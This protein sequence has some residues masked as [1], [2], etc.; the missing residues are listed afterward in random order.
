M[1][2][3]AYAAL[4][5]SAPALTLA[6]SRDCRWYRLPDP[7]SLPPEPKGPIL[8]ETGIP[9]KLQRIMRSA[10]KAK[11]LESMHLLDVTPGAS[12]VLTIL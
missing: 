10:E 5:A 1:R 7:D 6:A 11:R 4:N 3:N 9:K 8:D 12:A 2:A